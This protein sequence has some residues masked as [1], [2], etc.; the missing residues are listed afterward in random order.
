MNMNS[1]YAKILV[2]ILILI[3]EI[4]AIYAQITAAR[5][6]STTNP[7][8]QVF[9]KMFL[10]MAAG[11]GLLVAGYM[12]GFPAFKNIWIV[13]VISITSILITEPAAD[14][15]I[16]KQLPTTGAL[17]GLILGALGMISALFLK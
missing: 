7:F 8:M 2:I 16:F 14:Y 17:I 10:V 13:S 4:L 11:G 5:A 15:I 1:V 12:L 3:G 6:Y 9:W